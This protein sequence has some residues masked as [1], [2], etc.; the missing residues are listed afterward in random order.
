MCNSIRQT[1]IFL[2]SKQMI[3]Y[4]HNEEFNN[5]GL[6]YENEYVR[7]WTGISSSTLF[8]GDNQFKLKL[9]N[10]RNQIIILKYA[11]FQGM[12]VFCD[13]TELIEMI[14]PKIKRYMYIFAYCKWNYIFPT[15]ACI[16]YIYIFIYITSRKDKSIPSTGICYKKKGLH[17]IYIEII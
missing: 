5:N 2:K 15:N 11:C 6:V 10:I 16:R 7:P 13:K 14:L 3:Y 4:L 1:I 17:S 12:K 9:C 8:I